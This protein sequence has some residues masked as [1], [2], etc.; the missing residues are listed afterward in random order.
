M[1]VAAGREGSFRQSS[2]GPSCMKRCGRAEEL[3]KNS[4]LTR[5]AAFDL[6]AT[7]RGTIHERIAVAAVLA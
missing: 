5:N 1:N 2:S 7:P 4:P 6:R 3:C